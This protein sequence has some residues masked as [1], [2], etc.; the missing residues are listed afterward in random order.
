MCFE[1]VEVKT[2]EIPIEVSSCAVSLAA[3]TV[4]IAGDDSRTIYAFPGAE[5][6]E[7]PEIR[8]LLR[9][10]RR[11]HDTCASFTCR[12]ACSSHGTCTGADKCQC[13][14]GWDD[15]YC[16]FRLVQA[17]AE[18]D[19]NGGDGDD[20]A[21]WIH[22][23]RRPGAVAHHH[24]HQVRDR[25]RPRRLRPERHTSSPPRSRTTWTSSTGFPPGSERSI[26]R[27]P[28][29]VPTRRSGEFLLLSNMV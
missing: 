25:G 15:L 1:I 27:M 12:H 26:W 8:V 29:A 28:L 23:S 10:L 14:D 4:F 13:E 19:A 9:R 21:V 17:A 7:T 20:P 2:F 22:P 6:E 18:A 3:Q 11:R 5:S 24:H 16:R